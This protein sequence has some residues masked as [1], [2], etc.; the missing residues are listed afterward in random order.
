MLAHSTANKRDQLADVC[1]LFHFIRTFRCVD[2]LQHLLLK[3]IR[4]PL[5]IWLPEK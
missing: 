4:F 1:I 3:N 5:R 2:K